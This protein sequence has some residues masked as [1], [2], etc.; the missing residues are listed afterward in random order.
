MERLQIA[1]QT[2]M[3][4]IRSLAYAGLVILFSLPAVACN[5][6]VVPVS[7]A[8]PKA[9]HIVA[10]ALPDE[11]FISERAGYYDT[12][13]PS[14]HAD[15]WRSH[16]VLN[17]GLPADFSAEQLIVT[18]ATL[19]LPVWGYTRAKNEVFVLGGSPMALASFTQAIR[20][21]E[22]IKRRASFLST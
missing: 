7:I 21:G 18:T 5:S 17:A 2:K 9:K 15:L 22:T 12:A 14:E 4:R 1:G 10:S 20:T 8:N 3:K 6:N 19:N 16:A 13:W 11:P